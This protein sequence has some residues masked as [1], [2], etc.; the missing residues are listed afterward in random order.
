MEKLVKISPRGSDCILFRFYKMSRGSC[1]C[2]YNASKKCSPPPL[3]R[4]SLL[5]AVTTSRGSNQ[6]VALIFVLAVLVLMLGLVLAFFS[7]ATQ[8]RQV[9]TASTATLKVAFVS[10][11]A[12]DLIVADLR[13]EMEEGS[14]I[15]PMEDPGVN[16]WRPT[17]VQ[18]PGDH[19]YVA[20]SM[21]PQNSGGQNARTTVKV[22]RA[23]TPFFAGGDAYRGIG[24]IRATTSSTA[25]NSLNARS[26]DPSRWQ[27][28]RL[29]SP[30]EAA[31][32]SP[33]DWIYI[34]RTGN[35]H[36]TI[37]N[38]AALASPAPLN[39]SH[40]LGR[41]AYVIYDIGGLWDANVVGNGLA[42]QDFPA[43]EPGNE[44]KGFLHQIS[45][46]E[47]VPT[48]GGTRIPF[49]TFDDFVAWR[50]P[51]S[52]QADKTDYLRTLFGAS[53]RSFTD[54]M[55][56][57]QALLGRSDLISLSTN[58]N[59]IPAAALPYLSTFSRDANRPSFAPQPNSPRIPNRSPGDTHA[60]ID[61]FQGDTPQSELDPDL[62]EP[63][64]RFSED[65]VVVRPDG[66]VLARAGTPVMSR[67][68]P[69]G[70]LSLFAKENPD[71]EELRYYFG[72]RRL[73]D[74]RFEYVERIPDENGL[75]K[76][77]SLK[78]LAGHRLGTGLVPDPEGSG[79]M[80]PAVRDPNFFEVIQAVVLAG[81]LG[82]TA[83]SPSANAAVPWNQIEDDI[84]PES[85]F[86][87]NTS[88]RAHVIDRQRNRQVLQIGANIIDQ[89]DA[90]DL[91]T[92]IRYPSGTPQV[93]SDPDDDRNFWAVH[94]QENLPYISTY[95]LVAHRPDYPLG[96]RYGESGGADGKD[97]LQ[98]WACFDVW[99]PHQNARTPSGIEAFR[100]VG[101]GHAQGQTH[102]SIVDFYNPATSVAD[103]IRRAIAPIQ[104]SG[105]RINVGA[106]A[107]SF[108]VNAYGAAADTNP[109]GGTLNAGSIRIGTS[110]QSNRW[111]I[112]ELNE[113]F[114]IEFRFPVNDPSGDSYREPTALWGPNQPPQSEDD[115][116]GVL[117]MHL[118]LRGPSGSSAGI[119]RKAE[120]ND[121][122]QRTLNF[123]FDRS[124]FAPYTATAPD[125]S[126]LRILDGNG[127]SIPTNQGL[128]VVK[129]SQGALMSGVPVGGG[130][131]IYPFGTRFS[132][133]IQTNIGT[134]AD[135]SE[136]L[137]DNIQMVSGRPTWVVDR[138]APTTAD[139]EPEVRVYSNPATKAQ[140]WIRISPNRSNGFHVNF[141]LEAL[142]DGQWKPYQTIEGWY[143][144]STTFG[145]TAIG[146]GSIMNPEIDAHHSD[147]PGLDFPDYFQHYSWR[148]PLKRVG[149][150]EVDASNR[151][152]FKSDPRTG[153]FGWSYHHSQ[154]PGVFL[155]NTPTIA[156]INSWVLVTASPDRALGRNF[157]GTT[158]PA[159]TSMNLATN[160]LGFEN[161]SVNFNQTAIGGLIAN[162]PDEPMSA[163]NP[164]RYADIDGVV[165]PADGYWGALP[166][167]PG[168]REDRQVI[169]NRPFRS[170]GEL[171]YVFRDTPWKTL[172]FSTPQSGDFG[173][174]DAFTLQSPEPASPAVAGKIAINSAQPEVLAE[175]LRGA[176]RLQV[177]SGED[178]VL[179][180]EDASAIAA[181]IARQAGE[182]GAP[183]ATVGEFATRDV[184]SPVLGR[185]LQAG[186]GAGN[187]RK[188]EREAA[189]RTLSGIGSTGTWNLLID[190]V[191]Q[192]GTFSP[193]SRTADDFLVESESRLWVHLA[194]D[195]FTGQIV[196][197][198]IERAP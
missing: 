198:Q 25:G 118:D 160:A 115:V 135:G 81:S 35:T 95:T 133:S 180:D 34:D 140:N 74:G 169:L 162:N 85:H 96:S 114:D 190:L 94:G 125:G 52:Q 26:I 41:Y 79:R 164:M 120:R 48:A 29:L 97:F 83:G 183:F 23:N 182:L 195:R 24:E 46:A 19:R 105:I 30:A 91:P 28:I 131:R 99:N 20:P 16:A 119:P 14:E 50:W 187:R 141:S 197:M 123:V 45:L 184:V 38:P 49:A 60:I 145:T 2:K 36:A 109:H 106:N 39:S 137:Q 130:D 54:I 150:T 153:R 44:A 40:I 121:D 132:G 186:P 196:D 108:I 88:V 110:T 59:L 17:W 66:H 77:G 53:A 128:S 87:D 113:Q 136:I 175:I 163:Q 111:R 9:S 69:L 112:D 142:I 4:H 173:L 178:I 134:A 37:E 157:A 51:R 101:S 168:F 167:V 177:P 67:R 151:M 62:L 63:D 72:L 185:G 129:T 22:S 18:L 189:I 3:V 103:T 13:Q 176:L 159:Y 93:P 143:A 76:L 117:L 107:D 84:I 139:P 155:R 144:M 172:D 154:L 192:S 75:L 80:L 42:K 21:V 116:P 147:A 57:D 32:F 70:K 193:A 90:D 65:V 102:Y 71:P 191:T 47:G 12:L 181:E 33:P 126:P 188:T 170:V 158:W 55:E 161:F 10:Q 7:R 127:N 68:F 174:L 148:K 138:P 166:T 58:S 165:R 92:T 11:I 64:V 179:S 1:R 73:D 89:W 27:E 124:T 5:G 146:I 152:S 15:D 8:Q 82:K 6:G 171:G 43:G 156:N 98:M 122:L 31:D 104:D 86:W 56:G 194:M 149:T 61:P 78:S 100:I